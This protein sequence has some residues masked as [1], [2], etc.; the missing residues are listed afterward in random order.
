MKDRLHRQ[1]FLDNDDVVVTEKV[2]D[3]YGYWMQAD[4]LSLFNGTS[5]IL[6][7]K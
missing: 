5:F 7:E 4:L 2:A 1:D 3:F 6:V